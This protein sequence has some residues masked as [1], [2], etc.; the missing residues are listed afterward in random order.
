MALRVM[1]ITKAGNGTAGVVCLC[2]VVLVFPFLAQAQTTPFSVTI[3]VGQEWRTATPPSFDAQGIAYVSLTSA[4]RQLGAGLREADGLWH[5]DFLGKSAALGVNSTQVSAPAG[6]FQ[7]QHPVLRYDSD[8][9][10]AASDVSAFFTSGFQAAL[11]T[12]GTNAQPPLQKPAQSPLQTPIQPPSAPSQPAENPDESEAQLAGHVP[13]PAPPPPSPPAEGE[14]SPAAPPLPPAVSEGE[15]PPAAPLPPAA[16]TEGEPS[17]AAP[18]AESGVVVVIDPGHGGSDTGCVGVGGLVEKDLTLAIAK[19]VQQG[20]KGVPGVRVITT[21]DDDRD[22]AYRNRINF[23]SVEKAALVVSL[24]GG[25]S[26]ASKAQGC[27]VYYPRQP[28]VTT[29]PAGAAPSAPPSWVE[30]SA[31]AGKALA[32][33]LAAKTGGEVRAARPMPLLLFRGMAIPGVVIE[34]GVLTSPGDE[35]A[36][37]TD[38]FQQKLAQGIAEGIS[39]ALSLQLP[40]GG[41]P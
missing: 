13:A 20:L 5:M 18:P 8:V 19:K 40:Q 38:E 16:S 33:S 10:I 41:T 31:R 29:T 25:A 7:L 22:V 6:S 36:L 12:P 21:R 11:G 26:Y 3:Q 28:D 23:A 9:L 39:V 2:F 15:A 4:A 34:V 1:S 27:E 24:H 30:T 32:E 35:A 37:K 14:P 17:P